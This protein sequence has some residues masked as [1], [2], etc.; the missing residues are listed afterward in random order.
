[1]RPGWELRLA[2]LGRPRRERFRVRVRC[3]ERRLNPGRPV[4][5]EVR[6]GDGDVIAAARARSSGDAERLA[7]IAIRRHARRHA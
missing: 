3:C 6:D 5:W 1:M 2:D 7:T 4:L